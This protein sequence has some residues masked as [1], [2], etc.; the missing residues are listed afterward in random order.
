MDQLL[1]QGVYMLRAFAGAG[2]DGALAAAESLRD[3]RMLLTA[4]TWGTVRSARGVATAPSLL[5]G[6]QHGSMLLF[7]PFELCRWVG[8]VS[9]P[10]SDPSFAAQRVA[11]GLWLFWIVTTSIITGRRLAEIR[12]GPAAAAASPAASERRCLTL[13]LAKLA[14]DGP[15]AAHFLLGLGFPLL[16]VGCLGTA[17][18]ILG[19]RASLLDPATP[20]SRVGV[21]MPVRLRAS[22][23]ACWG[24]VRPAVPDCARRLTAISA[25]RPAPPD[26]RVVGGISAG[27]LS[28]SCEW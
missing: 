11:S 18:S 10:G 16:A 28:R 26:R 21:P 13:R 9:R 17:S 23:S 27:P 5:P 8:R 2:A 1:R 6:L 14:L 3:A 15:L 12:R 22:S 24:S 19:V 20:P 4:S 25:R 7:H